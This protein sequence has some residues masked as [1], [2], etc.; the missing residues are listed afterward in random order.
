MRITLVLAFALSCIAQATLGSCVPVYDHAQRTFKCKGDDGI[1]RFNKE[2]YAAL[3]SGD[4]LH[5]LSEIMQHNTMQRLRG[6]VKAWI[7]RQKV[8]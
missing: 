8:Q 6:N 7:R 1:D 3:D 5:E 2:C 4:D